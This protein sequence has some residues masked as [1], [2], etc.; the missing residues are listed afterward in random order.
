[1]NIFLCTYCPSL[2]FIYEISWNI[3]K[4]QECAFKIFKVL[5][6]Y[7]IS[8]WNDI[9]IVFIINKFTKFIYF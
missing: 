4:V 3:V 1:M 5:Y 9:K 6:V 8:N 2:S 7:S